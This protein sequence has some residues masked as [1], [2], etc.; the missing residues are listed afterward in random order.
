MNYDAFTT[1]HH[2]YQGDSRN[3]SHLKTSS[4][5]LIVTSPPYPIIEMWDDVFINLDPS[6]KADMD[7]ARPM[8]AFEK[9]HVILDKVWQE[10]FRLLRPGCFL[11]INIGD[12]VRTLG[13]DFMLYSNHARILSA[14]TGIGFQVLPAIIWR[15]QTN[16]PNKFMGS[17]MLPAGAYVTLEHE[18]I[19]I[20]R[21]GGKRL[22][23]GN[24]RQ[25]RQSSAFFWEER[26][27]FFSDL[28]DFKGTRQMFSKSADAQPGKLRERSAAYPFELPFRLINMYSL[29]GDT[30]LDPFFG[31]GT[32]TAA[33]AVSGRSSIG[34]EIDPAL[35]HFSTPYLEQLLASG[36]ERQLD[37]LKNHRSFLDRRREEGKP[38]PKHQ[39]ET[40]G[41]PVVT[42]QE[43][44][45]L[46]PSITGIDRE[47]DKQLLMHHGIIREEDAEGGVKA[48]SASIAENS[49]GLQGAAAP[50]QQL[51]LEDL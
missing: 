49:T 12:A 17:G 47:G 37:R 36:R 42:G 25:K 23:D 39:N 19:L 15:K 30:V 27:Q 20:L 48:L 32:T 5:E 35:A 1:T 13:P 18:Y 38:E 26:N 50:G 11:C 14:C 33:A 41:F 2:L 29:I 28:W 6:I 3:L 4:V 51:F 46:I 16:A 8:E 21:K 34:I 44:K 45:L 22:F 10:C 24:G 31:T 43:K 9:M 40:Y 7:G